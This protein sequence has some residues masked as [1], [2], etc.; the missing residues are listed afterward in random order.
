MTWVSLII[1]ANLLV[2]PGT[3]LASAAQPR[4][5]ENWNR[6]IVIKLNRTNY[7]HAAV[8]WALTQKLA[9]TSSRTPLA[10]TVLSVSV[11]TKD[12]REC[13]HLDKA[14][15]SS[16]TII[17]QIREIARRLKAWM[18]VRYECNTTTRVYEMLQFS[19]DELTL[20]G[21]LKPHS[22]GPLYSNTVIGTLD[23][24]GWA[25]TFGTARRGLG[26]MRP[27]PVPF[28]LYQM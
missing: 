26:W 21:R 24:D 19:C 10:A 3:R 25:V 23:V 27:C 16:M 11:T 14:A 9:M 28:L 20:M 13:L 15:R 22:N 6:K 17:R 1:D 12:H 4:K 18:Q 7:P 5:I 8:M 2:G